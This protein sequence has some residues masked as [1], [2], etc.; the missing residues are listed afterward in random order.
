MDRF[1]R[2]LRDLQ[3][4]QLCISGA[5]LAAVLRVLDGQ[6]AMEPVPIKKLDGRWILTDGHTRATAAWMRGERTIPVVAETEDLDWEAYRITVGWCRR[7][8]IRS[9]TDLS[10]RVVSRE[11]YAEAWLER[12]RRMHGELEYRRNGDGVTSNGGGETTGAG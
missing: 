2:D 7:E 9:V 12:C 6:E 1:E 4:S 3:P 5:K 8:G 10:R 11:V